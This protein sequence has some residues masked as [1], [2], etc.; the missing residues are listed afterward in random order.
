MPDVRRRTRGPTPPPSS[1]FLRG[2]QELLGAEGAG[3]AEGTGRLQLA[4]CGDAHAPVRLPPPRHVGRAAPRLLQQRWRSRGS[5]A[6]S[7][8]TE[9]GRTCATIA[10]SSAVAWATRG[11]ASPTT[12]ASRGVRPALARM[13]AS[14]SSPDTSRRSRRWHG[15]PA[16]PVR[17]RRSPPPAAA[18]PVRAQRRVPNRVRGGRRLPAPVPPSRVAM[19]SGNVR[20]S[21][22]RRSMSTGRR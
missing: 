5:I 15:R 3:G 8:E 6:S 22:P 14:R 20:A 17:W 9:A 1:A 7:A 18:T 19:P 4:P 10:R 11:K 2:R 13:V 21:A 12:T 16:A